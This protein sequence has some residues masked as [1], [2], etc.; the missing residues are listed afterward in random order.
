MKDRKN[1]P[2]N[3]DETEIALYHLIFLGNLIENTMKAFTNIIRKVDDS[4]EN[5]LWVS[6]CSIILIQTVSFLD[7]FD[8][9]I[10]S[11][12]IE[13]NNTIKA[14][15]KAVK[16]ALKQIK[17][18]VELRDFR[19]NVLAH[20]LRNEKKAISVFRRGLSSYDIPKSGS[21]FA[22]LVSSVSM[23][24]KTFESAFGEKILKVQIAIDRNEQPLKGN[25]FN[26]QTEAEDVISRITEEINANILQLKNSIL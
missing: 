20:N 16:P 21:D 22:V 24:K 13:L 9:F 15:K 11:N 3:F 17:Q 4:D 1:L 26:N 18:W 14:I 25:R 12:D 5:A 8:N 7:E 19:N 2:E 10:K 23:I 6:T